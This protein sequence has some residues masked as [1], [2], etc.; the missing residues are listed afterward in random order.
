MARQ[1]LQAVPVKREVSPM[2][3]WSKCRLSRNDQ[4][5]CNNMV[6]L[7]ILTHES[8]MF[9]CEQVTDVSGLTA[10]EA[11]RARGMKS[12]MGDL[13]WAVRAWGDSHNENHC[14]KN[15]LTGNLLVV[16]SLVDALS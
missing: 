13:F 3:S 16:K 2:L 9:R 10:T 6:S 11:L 1:I 7:G 14:V 5:Q 4:I 12:L 8:R 15:A